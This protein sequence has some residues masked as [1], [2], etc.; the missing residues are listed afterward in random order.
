M[1]G[2]V[3]S[4]DDESS[5]DTYVRGFRD[6]LTKIS[7]KSRLEVYTNFAHGDE[8]ASAWYSAAHVTKLKQLKKVY[9]PNSLFSFFNPIV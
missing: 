5:I 8:G 7:G 2:T 6:S 4:P 3:T 1:S 9:D